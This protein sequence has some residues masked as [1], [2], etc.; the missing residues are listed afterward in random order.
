MATNPMHQFEV[1]KIGPE[2]NLVS[3]IFVSSSNKEQNLVTFASSKGAST[4]SK[5]QI[6]EGLVKKTANINDKAVRACSPP[7]NN[8]IDCSL[9]PGGL[10]SI[11]KPASNGSSDSTNSNFAVPPLKSFV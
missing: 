5:I 3:V 10:T 6:G 7:D 4:S 1:Y 9:L 11:S 8:V 2:I